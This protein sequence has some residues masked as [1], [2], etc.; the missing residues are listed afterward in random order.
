MRNLY[1]K[2]LLH[3]FGVG[4]KPK[5][6][7]GW[8]GEYATW[9]AAS[10]L[11]EGY[12]KADILDKTRQSLMK[13]RSGEAVYERDSVL[14]AEKQFPFP[15][16]SCLLHVASANNNSLNVIDFGGSLGSTWYQVKDFLAHLTTINW[17]V[18]EQ[19][20][21]VTC[22]KADFE[23]DV[24]RFF[25]TIEESMAVNKPDVILLSSVVQYLEKPHQF[26][27]ELVK[28]SPA[29]IIFDR[30]AFVDEGSDR[31]TVQY[32]NPAIYDAS[33]P[34]W[35]FNLEGFLKHFAEY[36]CLAEFSSCVEGEAVLQIDGKAQAKDKGFFFK[37]KL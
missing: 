32:V 27:S 10:A 30:T 5:S 15:L 17:H 28:L 16:I 12:D 2:G 20:N 4:R 1:Y 26:L 9:E 37:R 18:V 36:T 8:F 33:Y 24:L 22:G 14:F 23:D 21:Y 34:A 13:I 31:I 7:Y 29:Y 6:A 35:F 19:E 11:T 3:Q 25:Y